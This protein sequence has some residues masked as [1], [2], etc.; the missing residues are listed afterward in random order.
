[1]TSG[2]EHLD[3]VRDRFTH[4]AAPFA[5]FALTVR[6]EEAVRLAAMATRSLP[7]TEAAVAADLACGP[8][9]FAV[10]LAARVGYVV[11][12]DLTPAMLGQARETLQR[13]GLA[14]AAYVCANAY[15]LPFADGTL[16]IALC[17]YALHHLLT[18]ERAIREMARVVRP[19]G[20]V[21][22][23]DLILDEDADSEAHNRIERSRDP[24]HATT[25]RP[26]ALRSLFAQAGL[27]ELDG[28]L[29]ERQRD[30]GHWMEVAGWTP[31]SETYLRTRRLMEAAIADG[32]TGLQPRKGPD[33]R[34]LQ[35]SQTVLSLVAEK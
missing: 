1:M 34:G 27:R 2:Q 25:L 30:F 24:S 5:Q 28:D 11:G 35:F 22:V 7:R 23:V 12:V 20:R 14:N 18:P 29:R 33:G 32:D 10:A 9:T 4:T 26:S 17:G 16:D 31:G 21:V 8:G 6:A 19:G 13:A 15:T 3:R